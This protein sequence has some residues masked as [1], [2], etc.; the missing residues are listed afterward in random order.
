MEVVCT[1][2]R[3]G[4]TIPQTHP[5]DAAFL[6][7]NKECEG[8]L[9]FKGTTGGL[10]NRVYGC[11]HPFKVGPFSTPDDALRS[12]PTSQVAG[13]RTFACPRETSCK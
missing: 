4:D 3:T 7:A 8:R 1:Y 12:G 5:S 11:G 10:T 6:R 2:Y 13:R 9:L